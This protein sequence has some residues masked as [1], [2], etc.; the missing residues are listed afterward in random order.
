MIKKAF[1]N[2]CNKYFHKATPQEK[3][4]VNNLKV[5]NYQVNNFC[6][7]AC[8]MCNVWKKKDYS[9][10]SLKEFEKIL[11]DSLFENIEH[12]G[13]TGGEPTLVE[14]LS[15]YFLCA[16]E[17]LPNL[18]GTSLITN[19]LAPEK[20]IASIDKIRSISLQKEKSF[21]IMLSLDGVRTFHDLNRGRKGNFEQVMK[22]ISYLQE[23]KIQFTIGATAT[24]KNVWGLD[25]LLLFLKEK[26]IEGRFRIGE[27]INRL[28]NDCEENKQYIR[29]FSD[30][31]IYQLELF[32]S[33]LEYSYEKNEG[34]L[35][36]Y[37]N[38]KRML[39]GEE[40]AIE[41]PYKNGVAINLDCHGGMAYCAPKSPVIGNL[42][43]DRGVNIYSKNLIELETIKQKYCLKCIH[44]YHDAPKQQLVEVLE[45]QNKYKNFFSIQAY[46]SKKNDV[47]IN[48]KEF[49]APTILI[50]GWYGTE[51]VGDKAILGQVIDDYKR[52]Y[53]KDLCIGVSSLYP[54]ITERT[55]RELNVDGNVKVV[56]VYSQLYFEWCASV[57]E[58]VVGG[59]PLM[60]LEELSLIQWAFFIAKEYSRKRTVY[61][62]GIGP[63][64][65]EDKKQAVKEIL[66]FANEV[67][68]R[69]EAS[70]IYAKKIGISELNL[71]NIGDPAVQFIKK[72]KLNDIKPKKGKLACFLREITY[73]Y[74]G[75]KSP[76][77]F[78][79]FKRNFEE[80]LAQNIIYL[81]KKENLIPHFYAMHNFVIG[82]DDRDFNLSFAERYLQGYE[83]Y[84]ERKL[85]TIESISQNMQSAEYNLCMRFHSVLFANILQVPYI[86]IDYTGGGKIFQLLKEKNEMEKIVSLQEIES[87]G[88]RVLND[89]IK[90]KWCV[91]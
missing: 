54:F 85:S 76:E 83:Y 60:E 30:D 40:R 78:D 72:Y 75:N 47:V 13:I 1:S 39:R 65:T 28:D 5:I 3:Q 2:L 17:T 82:N 74:R 89:K 61:G 43:Q 67:N 49:G 44:D 69:D 52:K 15:E 71:H 86:A 9:Y 14:D 51:T 48:M 50:V 79:V 68:L 23:N 34:I 20:V 29:N 66:E 70:V 10:L 35:N 80:R 21:V 26:N 32:F 7:S 84:I 87:N 73:E 91:E 6:N 36:T 88:E 46:K 59:G 27:F 22:V 45:K 33:K 77:E 41:C 63:L 19:C 37:R 58:V 57:D 16:M 12:I 62:C 11:D 25:E 56:P 55:L 18:K 42:L 90:G 81:I 31:E 4:I 38:I 8:V 24:K 53:G 64:Y